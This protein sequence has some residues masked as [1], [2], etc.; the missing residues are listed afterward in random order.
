[1]LISTR[2]FVVF[3]PRHKN[4]SDESPPVE[5]VL[6][7]KRDV[8][9]DEITV[10]L[11]S[12]HQWITHQRLLWDFLPRRRNAS[13][14]NSKWHCEYLDSLARFSSPNGRLSQ[15]IC[16]YFQLEY[17]LD[18][19]HKSFSDSVTCSCL[20][21]DHCYYHGRIVNDSGSAVSISTC[22][23]LRWAPE[24]FSLWPNGSLKCPEIIRKLRMER[25][26]SNTD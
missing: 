10:I 12:H 13:H 21:Q 18:S 19:F 7:E 5:N 15:T 24:Q 6:Q 20:P 3:L 23:G 2:A 17:K 16:S 22:D 25:T 26:E 14:H 9:Q 11:F 1:M 8:T 4:K